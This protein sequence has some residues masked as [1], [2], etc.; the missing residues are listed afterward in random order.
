MIDT[1]TTERI[2]LL[3]GDIHDRNEMV[4]IYRV[5]REIPTLDGGHDMAE[6]TDAI[7]KEA[8]RIKAA[9]SWHRDDERKSNGHDT[10]GKLAV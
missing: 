10:A 6:L 4:H 8:M 3:V 1:A 2:R 9:M 5:A 7:A